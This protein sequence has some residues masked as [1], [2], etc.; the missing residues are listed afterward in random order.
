[1]ILDNVQSIK[2]LITSINKPL[3]A[4]YEAYRLDL[5]FDPKYPNKRQTTG[6]MTR[7]VK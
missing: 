3:S 7:P 1:V 5:T 2:A 6:T 4:F